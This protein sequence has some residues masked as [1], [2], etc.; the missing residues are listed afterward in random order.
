MIPKAELLRKIVS[1]ENKLN[2]IYK[3]LPSVEYINDNEALLISMGYSSEE[4][5][6]LFS[7][8]CTYKREFL[9]NPN[10]GQKVMLFMG[11][12]TI[13][14]HPQSGKYE[15]YI[16]DIPYEEFIKLCMIKTENLENLSFKYP[17]IR[18]LMFENEKL[19]ETIALFIKRADF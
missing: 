4:I 11:K 1:L 17:E 3:Y 13:E 5:K 12:T 19:R 16:N 6:E 15:L 10:N 14:K 7:T 9:I 2:L 8:G 18:E